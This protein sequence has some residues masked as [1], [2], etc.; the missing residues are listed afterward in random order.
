MRDDLKRMAE[1]EEP[2][3]GLAVERLRA[4]WA[5]R[6]WL[7]VLVFALPF[8]AALSVIFALPTFYRS[9]ALVLVERQ[10]VPEAFVPSTV[11]SELETRLHT[12]SQEIL[13]RSRLE[14][15]ITRL[16][17]YPGLRKQVSTE[18][19]VERMR[20]D[21]KLE[22]KTTNAREGRQNATTAFALSYRGSDP[23]TVA[24]VTN[25]I[26]SFYIEENLKVRERQATGTAEF[27][28]VQL[29][30]TRKRLDELE[31]RVS[32]FRR[33]YLGELP[34]QMQANLAS[35]ESLNTQLRLASDNLLRAAERRESLTALLAEAASS[36]QAFGGSPGAAA[37][38]RTVRLT[39]LRQELAS[40]RARYT[41]EHPSV[42]RLKAELIATERESAEASAG[43]AGATAGLLNPYGMRLRETLSAT[44]SEMKVLKAEEQRL[45]AAIG[46]YQTRL[47]NT[48][49]REQ[50]FQEV[51]R[52]YEST[53]QHYESLGK[54][55]EAALLAE[56]MEQ[57]QKGETFRILD[58]AFPS[59]IPA[60]PNRLKLFVMSLVLCVGLGGGALMLAEMLDTSFHSTAE[61]RE[62]SVVPVLVSIPRIV[63]EADRRRRQRRFRLAAAGAMLGLILIAGGSYF[64]GHGNEQLVQFL[65]RDGS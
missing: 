24:L 51:S 40:A 27:L 1:D 16:G 18:E 61:L 36:P 49:K 43:G 38:P 8:V 15:L 12:I 39:R 13:S 30:E 5:R 33:R 10:Q 59:N 19:L 22:L 31:A 25:T 64:I 50:E 62:F 4:A 46:A 28:K 44:E 20:K 54:R 3:K 52:D 2:Q 42:G 17:L 35:L 48:P 32:E 65:A 63:T 37:E 9:T 6:K 29:T 47:E 34:Q 23:Q 11:T 21:V 14:S 55:Y 53:R 26:A 56:S 41:E 57:R 58:P 45:R 60:A 7:A